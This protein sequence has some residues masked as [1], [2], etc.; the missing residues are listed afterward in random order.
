TSLLV[1]FAKKLRKSLNIT[2]NSHCQG[3]VNQREAWSSSPAFA[4]EKFRSL[5]YENISPEEN[6]EAERTTVLL[7]LYKPIIDYYIWE[8]L[9]ENEN[10]GSTGNGQEAPVTTTGKTIIKYQIYLPSGA[11]HSVSALACRPLTLPLPFLCPLTSQP[12]LNPRLALDL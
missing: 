8:D 4:F 6:Q 10:I 3:V 1:T 5:N 12:P 11:E 7:D 2:G 9:E